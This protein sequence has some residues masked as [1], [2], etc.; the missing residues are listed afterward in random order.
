MLVSSISTVKFQYQIFPPLPHSFSVHPFTLQWSFLSP[1]Q[2][3]NRDERDWER[4]ERGEQ[5]R[6]ESGREVICICILVR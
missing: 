4:Q 1:I 3:L 5:E 6:A 2:F